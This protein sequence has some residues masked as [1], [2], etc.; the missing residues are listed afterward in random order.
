MA[1]AFKL[2]VQEEIH[3]LAGQACTHDAAAHAQS[4]GIVVAAGILAAEAVRAA[5]GTNALEDR[6]STRLNSSHTT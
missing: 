4:V 5:A 6:K 2:G 1:A 3:Q